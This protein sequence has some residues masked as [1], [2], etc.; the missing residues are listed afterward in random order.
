MNQLMASMRKESM[1]QINEDKF[2]MFACRLPKTERAEKVYQLHEAGFEVGKMCGLYGISPSYYRELKQINGKEWKLRLINDD[3]EIENF[4][5]KSV[6]IGHS[7]NIAEDR[8]YDVFGC[9][10]TSTVYTF[11]NIKE[12]ELIS[13]FESLLT[14]GIQAHV[15]DKH[16]KPNQN[17]DI[18]TPLSINY[19]PEKNLI[20]KQNERE[21]MYI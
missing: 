1:K 4:I 11:I 19:I 15:I 9:L 8:F 13:A 18:H 12:D 21:M 16:T 20:S 3:E 6:D 17:A 2:K 14:D 5:K 7:L 10:M